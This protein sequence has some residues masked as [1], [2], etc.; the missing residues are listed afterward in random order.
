MLVPLS[1]D[2]TLK[3]VPS[4]IIGNNELSIS[5]LIPAVEVDAIV[6]PLFIANQVILRKTGSKTT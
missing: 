5:S 4:K 2:C 1:I 3:N 6:R